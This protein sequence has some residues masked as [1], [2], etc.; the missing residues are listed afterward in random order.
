[1]ESL[2]FTTVSFSKPK[3]TTDRSFFIS[4]YYYYSFK[5]FLRFCKSGQLQLQESSCVLFFFYNLGLLLFKPQRD[6]QMSK[7]K[8]KRN[9]FW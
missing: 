2:F 9:E 6:W 8:Q 5:I 7:R 3:K 1:M 4:G